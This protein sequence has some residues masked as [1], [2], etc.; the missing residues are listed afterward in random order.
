MKKDLMKPDLIKDAVI[1]SQPAPHVAQVAINRP[2]AKN[3]IDEKTRLALIEAIQSVLADPDVR[4]LV[5]CGTEGIFCAGGDLT[6]MRGM[7]EQQ[8]RAHMQSGHQLV[9]LLWQAEIPVVVALEKYAIGAGAGLALLADYMIAGKNARMSFPFMQLGLVPDWGST[10]ALIRRT[11]WSTAKRLIL[12]KASLKGQQLLE[13]NIADK[14]VEDESV[15]QTA[16]NKAADFTHYPRLAFRLF[17]TRM[18]TYPE[19]FGDALNAEENDQTACFLGAEF[20][21]GLSALQQKRSPD[22]INNPNEI[23]KK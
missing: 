22:F 17:K 6:S 21:E 19:S 18:Q 14:I 7:S 2:E 5:L 16:C 12:D 13:L 9:N 1:I 4:A 10:Q 3:A 23:N 20:E 11:G 8:A 15:L